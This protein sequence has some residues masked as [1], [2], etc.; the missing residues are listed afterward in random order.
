[1]VLSQNSVSAQGNAPQVL[2]GLF[3]ENNSNA[4][5]LQMITSSNHGKSLYIAR[6]SSVSTK[7][8]TRQ[9]SANTS[10]NIHHTVGVIEVLS[11]LI[12]PQITSPFVVD[13]AIEIS[14]SNHVPALIGMRPGQYWLLVYD[15]HAMRSQP[16]ETASDNNLD[17]SFVISGRD[18]PILS[19]YRQYR[20]WT[21]GYVG[22]KALLAARTRL[23]DA[24]AP[25]VIRAAA[26]YALLIKI[27][28][29]DMDRLAPVPV[30]NVKVKHYFNK[31]AF[32][33]HSLTL[34]L[35]MQH[36][37]GALR[38]IAINAIVV[39]SKLETIVGSDQEA[40][41]KYL[42]EVVRNNPSVEIV[43]AAASQLYTTFATDVRT[44]YYFPDVLNVLELRADADKKGATPQLSGAIGAL[45]NLRINGL[46]HP[47]EIVGIKIIH[48]YLNP[49]PENA[50]ERMLSIAAKE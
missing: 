15:N 16:I 31:Q 14:S 41:L 34:L 48:R 2:Q 47:E 22:E 19:A 21:Q 45:N 4:G 40:Q 8:S 42:L 13:S 33:V 3:K 6:V 1:M 25:E 28:A 39:N 29:N 11:S 37:P 27:E 23:L 49:S 26:L 30:L 5:L 44:I 50:I 24:E 43:E 36:L 20:I 32:G 10:I 9:F 7:I 12:G 35:A 38:L 18:D 46:R 17:G